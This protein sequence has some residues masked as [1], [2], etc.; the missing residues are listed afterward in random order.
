VGSEKDL[1]KILEKFKVSIQG[2]SRLNS[3]EEKLKHCV[4]TIRKAQGIPSNAILTQGDVALFSQLLADSWQ[5]TIQYQDVLHAN[6]DVHHNVLF[7]FEAG[8]CQVTSELFSL[9]LIVTEAEPDKSSNCH[10]MQV[11]EFFNVISV[12]RMFG[13]KHVTITKKNGVRPVN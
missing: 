2:S 6:Y 9:P 1:Q 5:A 7:R 10:M 13:G 4:E 11:K 12:I 8:K 3:L